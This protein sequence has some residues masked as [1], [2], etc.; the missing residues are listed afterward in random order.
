MMK[1]YEFVSQHAVNLFLESLR[2]VRICDDSVRIR[3]DTALD[4]ERVLKANVHVCTKCMIV[5]LLTT[6]LNLKK[7]KK[8]KEKRKEKK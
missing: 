1:C 7:K 8:K 3:K 4:Q 2:S 5:S 6:C